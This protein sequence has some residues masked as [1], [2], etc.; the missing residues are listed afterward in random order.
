[1]V[2]KKS[3]LIRSLHSN[4]CY[5]CYNYMRQ[6][7]KNQL[8]LF[9]CVYLAYVI[10]RH[11]TRKRKKYAWFHEACEYSRF[12]F[13]PA[14]K[15]ETRRENFA[16]S[17]VTGANERPLCIRRLGFMLVLFSISFSLFCF[18]KACFA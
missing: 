2:C 1:M 5:Q 6:K 7:N 10:E 3:F 17:I 13:A 4:Q 11:L 9:F 8:W 15:R 18:K 16:C 12:S 14:T